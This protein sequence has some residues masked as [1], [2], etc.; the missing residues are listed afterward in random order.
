VNVV[1]AHIAGVPVEETIG[2][3]G[4]AMLVMF[5]AATVNLRA[6]WKGRRGRT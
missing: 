2:A 3:L 4:P 5:G 1:I 6:R